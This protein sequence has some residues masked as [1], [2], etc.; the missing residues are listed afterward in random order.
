[1]NRRTFIK[2][3]I[4][5]NIL[6][7]TGLYVLDFRWAV[8]R[9]LLDDTA[10]LK[11]DRKAIDKFIM[12][13][14]HEQFWRQFSLPKKMF[15]AIHHAVSIIGIKLPYHEKYVQYRNVITGQ[16]LLSTDLFFSRYNRGKK[17]KYLG[18]MNPY[19]TGCSNP[20]SNLRRP[21]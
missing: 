2:I 20:F 5:T 9:M 10:T 4:V 1:M 16:F 13:A 7:W 8:K 19:K 12:E 21:A 18:F 17:I 14:D 11:I 3:G 6:V 15:I